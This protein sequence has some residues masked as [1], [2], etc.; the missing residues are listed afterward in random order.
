MKTEKYSSMTWTYREVLSLQSFCKKKIYISVFPKNQRRALQHQRNVIKFFVHETFFYVRSKS[1]R[2]FFLSFCEYHTVCVGKRLFGPKGLFLERFVNITR[3]G[4]VNLYV[5]K[6]LF[7][8]EGSFL[9][10]RQSRSGSL[11]DQRSML[12]KGKCLWIHF[13]MKER[14][15]LLNQYSLF[16]SIEEKVNAIER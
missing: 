7:G 4:W 12:L 11:P 3:C 1:Q 9:L 5:C 2:A 8:P 16:C 13:T 14:T 6:R 15:T 10:E